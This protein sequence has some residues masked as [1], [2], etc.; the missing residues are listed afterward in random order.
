MCTKKDSQ[1]IDTL[2]KMR[3]NLK[4]FKKSGNLWISERLMPFGQNVLNLLRRNLCFYSK[5]LFY[6]MLRTFKDPIRTG[7]GAKNEDIKIECKLKR[8]FKI[9]GI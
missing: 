4:C 6:L 9:H 8:V 2:Q 7:L 3:S 1:T 5:A